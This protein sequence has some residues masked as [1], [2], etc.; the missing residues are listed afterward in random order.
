MGGAGGPHAG[1]RRRAG[2][3]PVR[4][5]GSLRSGYGLRAEIRR[6]IVTLRGSI[7][8]CATKSSAICVARAIRIGVPGADSTRDAYREAM[9]ETRRAIREAY[10]DSFRGR[11]WFRSSSCTSC[12][13]RSSWRATRRWKKSVAVA[14]CSNAVWCGGDELA[15]DGAN[16]RQHPIDV[17]ARAAIVHDACAQHEAPAQLGAGQERLAPKLQP[18]QQ[19]LVQRRH[20][21]LVWRRR[22]EEAEAD[23]A[24]PAAPSARNPARRA[25]SRRGTRPAPDC[26]R[27]PPSAPQPELLHRHPDLQR[28][29]AARLLKAVLAEP[30]RAADA[31]AAAVGPQVRR[32]QAERRSH[33][34]RASRTSTSPAS[35]G[36]NSH[37]CGSSAT[38]S[39]RASGGQRARRS[40]V[41]R[42]AGP[43]YAASTCSQTPC[44]R[45]TRRSRRGR[46]SRRCW[47]CRRWRRPR[48]AGRAAR[49][50][51]RSPRR[52]RRRSSGS[53]R[54][55]GRPDR[56]AA[57]PQQ[58]DRLARAAVRLPA[59]C[60]TRTAAARSRSPLAR[61]S[62]PL[63]HVPRDGQRRQR[64][65]RA[66]ADQQAHRRSAGSR[67]ARG[68]T[69]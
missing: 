65:H 56:R 25:P 1:P 23:D 12:P 15:T 21:R 8:N 17:A 9:R 55:S 54:R 53:R 42:I 34:R 69:G 58:L 52:A 2:G 57:E 4:S 33:R 62:T 38:L 3:A 50:R 63:L 39:A 67:A 29:E 22:I 31:G 43:P 26:P 45:Q 5:P 18:F 24:Q 46:R 14:R 37:L 68:T 44:A 61:T 7:I 11:W 51:A 47:S 30:R 13:S 59:T 64:R 32:D 16:G 36:T 40:A 66:A 27:S 35:T 41:E 60:R 10:R 28:A 49:G 48:S 19:P 6:E 20:R